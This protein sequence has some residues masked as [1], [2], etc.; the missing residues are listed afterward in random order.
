MTPPSF[1]TLL[2]RREG[3]LADPPEN[4][5]WDYAVICSEGPTAGAMNLTYKEA[6]LDAQETLEDMLGCVPSAYK[7]VT[8]WTVHTLVQSASAIWTVNSQATSNLFAAL[9]D[10]SS[11]S[12]WI[13]KENVNIQDALSA[14]LLRADTAATTDDDLN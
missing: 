14:A 13:K 3:D 11:A 10:P 4:S 8:V 12:Q 1:A 6:L 5:A 2:T 7:E 9:L